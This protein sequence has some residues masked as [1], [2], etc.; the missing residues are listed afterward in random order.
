METSH[1][2]Q[3][4]KW[5][6]RQVDSANFFVPSESHS[7]GVRAGEGIGRT[8]LP[9]GFCSASR[10]TGTTRNVAPGAGA[11]QVE[12][13]RARPAASS[14]RVVN[15]ETNSCFHTRSERTILPTGSRYVCPG[16]K[17]RTDRAEVAGAG[18]VFKVQAQQCQA[19]TGGVMS[20]KKPKVVEILL[21]AE[22]NG[23]AGAAA[24]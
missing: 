13:M 8:P 18:E 10:W 3:D 1:S 5:L 6:K 24:R 7:I 11:H 4:V 2:A 21:G 19:T 22:I 17:S 20:W 12:I 23:Y 15:A 14:T 9:R 16:S